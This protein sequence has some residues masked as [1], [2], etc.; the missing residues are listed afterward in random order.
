MPR[1]LRSRSDCLLKILKQ[2]LYFSLAC[3]IFILSLRE[4]SCIH[5]IMKRLATI[6]L[7]FILSATFLGGESIIAPSSTDNSGQAAHSLPIKGLTAQQSLT[8]PNRVN[9]QELSDRLRDCS[10]ELPHASNIQLTRQGEQN[11]LR[12]TGNCNRAVASIATTTREQNTLP[13]DYNINKEVAASRHAR[14]YYIYALRH[15]II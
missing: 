11:Q 9:I 4:Q 10:F 1:G 12:H 6:L 5:Q 15:I 3:Y 7:L 2:V 13:S 8:D 14:G